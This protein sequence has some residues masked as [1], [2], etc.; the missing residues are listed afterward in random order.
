M[1]GP[2]PGEAAVDLRHDLHPLVA[3][4]LGLDPERTPTREE[5]GAMLAGRR[6]DGKKIGA[7]TIPR[8]ALSP[9][10]APGRRKS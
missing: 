5:I 8:C 9:I 10:S 4:G 6:A 3:K 2:Q 7:S 1:P